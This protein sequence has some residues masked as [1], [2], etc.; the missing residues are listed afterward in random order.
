MRRLISI[1]LALVLVIYTSAEPALALV[2]EHA[3]CLK[4]AVAQA[5]QP[6]CHSNHRAPKASL[7]ESH[8]MQ[9][10]CPNRCCMSA[11]RQTARPESSYGS[12]VAQHLVAGARIFVFQPLSQAE[13]PAPSGRSPPSRLFS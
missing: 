4:R 5:K 8:S 12:G 9:S 11:V 10:G 3:C 2:S 13:L 1:A 7:S 6:S